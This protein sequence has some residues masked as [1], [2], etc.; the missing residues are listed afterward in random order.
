LRLV[1][2]IYAYTIYAGKTFW[3]VH[4]ASFYPHEG[5]RLAGWQAFLCIAF[6]A[7]FS[8]LMW[9][10]RDHAYLPVGWLWYLGTLIPV[11]GLV[12]VGDQG[13]ADR[14]GYLPL[15]GI[16]VIVVW[17]FVELVRPCQLDLRAGLAVAAA[18]IAGLS[19]LT[20]R[21]IGYWRS[22][23]DLWSHALAVT[24]D[25]YM[26]EDFVGSALL[27]QAYEQN[28]QRYSDDALVHFKNAVRI[29]PADA[30]IQ[31]LVPTSTSTANCRKRSN[32][33]WWF[34]NSHQI[35]TWSRKR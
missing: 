31:I 13:M 14:Y 25:N 16:F 18:V 17:G 4:L 8:F 2:T 6:L 21:Q 29:N 30:I 27:L 23:Y 7:S 15:I 24:K 9:K 19:F 3:P 33:I 5:A 32:S 28:G 10:K 35:L 22:S 11:I 20:W 1:N 26:A 34:C 12:Q